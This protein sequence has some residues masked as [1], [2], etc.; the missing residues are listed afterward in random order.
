MI[1][2]K[3]I[4]IKST[5]TGQVMNVTNKAF[6]A[7]YQ[8]KGFTIVTR[9]NAGDGVKGPAASAKVTKN[10]PQS[11][12]GS[13]AAIAKGLGFIQNTEDAD[14]LASEAALSAGD[15]VKTNENDSNIIG[16]DDGG[17][18]PAAKRNRGRGN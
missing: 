7:V 11:E 6:E 12:I 18:R 14:R 5:K 16:D 15:P 3:N 2:L 4:V 8:G 13:A 10:E 17:E 1:Q 9:N